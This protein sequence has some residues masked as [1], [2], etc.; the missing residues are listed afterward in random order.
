LQL[1]ILIHAANIGFMVMFSAVVAPTVFKVL[2][3]KAAGAYLRKLFPRMFMF[4][5]ITSSCAALAALADSHSPNA[6]ISALV[7]LGF[8][9]NAFILTP[10]INKY[11]DALLAGDTAAK[12]MF[13]RLHLVSVSVFLV[14]LLTSGYIVITAYLSS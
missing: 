9:G 12:A 8:L 6:T 1:S 2:S 10:Q 7:A 14:Q 3:Q 5:F 13:G 4:G 11:R